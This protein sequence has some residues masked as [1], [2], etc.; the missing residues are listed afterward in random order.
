MI[1]HLKIK[2]QLRPELNGTSNKFVP[3]MAINV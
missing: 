2:H 3:E 1:Y